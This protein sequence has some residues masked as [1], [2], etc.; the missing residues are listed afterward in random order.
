M[1]NYNS[2]IYAKEF[3]QRIKQNTENQFYGLQLVTKVSPPV[4]LW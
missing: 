4:N 3:Q 2:D 1:G